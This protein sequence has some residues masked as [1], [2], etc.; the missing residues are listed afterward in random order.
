MARHEPDPFTYIHTERER[1]RRERERER[2]REISAPVNVLSKRPYA[3]VLGGTMCAKR[4]VAPSQ[5]AEVKGLEERKLCLHSSCHRFRL[6][7][8]MD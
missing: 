8:G 4:N 7:T 1:E 2:E 3:R 5:D 6:R